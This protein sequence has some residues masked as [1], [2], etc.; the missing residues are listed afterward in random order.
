MEV[1]NKYNQQHQNFLAL[2]KR[3][4]GLQKSLDDLQ[5]NLA[6][7]MKNLKDINIPSS[8]IDVRRMESRP[9]QTPSPQFNTIK[10][11]TI[12]E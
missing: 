11:Q 8:V 9:T 4:D 6:V 1:V 5:I 12:D 2:S 7:I 10:T 3:M